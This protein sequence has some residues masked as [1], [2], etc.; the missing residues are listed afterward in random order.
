MTSKLK[1]SLIERS[2]EQAMEV[3][4]RHNIRLPPF[5]YWT[6]D[7]WL[8]KGHEVDEIRDCMLG[9]DVTDFGLGD[10]ARFGRTLFTLR[11]GSPGGQYPKPYAEKLLLNPEGQR[12]PAHFHRSKMEDI[13]NRAGGVIVVRVWAPD[14][15]GQK[16]ASPLRIQVDGETV[17]LE[18]GGL[19]RL[20][21]GQSVSLPPGTIH[22][23]WAEEGTGITVSSEVS[24]VNDDRRDNYFLTSVSRFPA[25]EEDEPLRY[26]LCHEYPPAAR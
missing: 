14:E 20:Q 24:S 11:N 19:V 4:D 2:L 15:R 10:F 9:W 12:A 7:D 18:A 26:Y 3:F 13:T 21:P 16:S 23:F 22:Q 8:R 6:V 5:A 1:R 17:P 25:I